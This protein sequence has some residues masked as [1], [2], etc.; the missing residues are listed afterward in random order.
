MALVCLSTH[1]S[2][3]LSVTLVINTVQDIGN[4]LHCI[5]ER[6]VEAKL[7]NPEFRD[8]PQMCALKRGIPFD[9]KNLTSKP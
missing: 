2:V 9:G 5:I 3:C 8:S 7:H 4:A 1:L 6:C